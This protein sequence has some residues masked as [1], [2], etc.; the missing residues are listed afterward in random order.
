MV[1]VFIIRR[2]FMKKGFH[3]YLLAGS[4]LLSSPSLFPMDCKETQHSF[5][6]ETTGVVKKL[7]GC[8]NTFGEICV[9]LSFYGGEEDRLM[10]PEGAWFSINIF[11]LF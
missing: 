9:G 4:L 8:F 3:F 1:T 2:V 5:E 6:F 7:E 10:L 11:L